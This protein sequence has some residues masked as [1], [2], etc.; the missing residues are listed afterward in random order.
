MKIMGKTKKNLEED[1]TREL[2]DIYP[3][4][5]TKTS[6]MF[7][8]NY[9]NAREGSMYQVWD[10]GAMARLGTLY[11]TER[12]QNS[13]TE[14]QFSPIQIDSIDWLNFMFLRTD[15]STTVRKEEL[16]GLQPRLK[17]PPQNKK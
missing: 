9:T 13:Y 15:E 6:I 17:R 3:F 10:L 14:F 7:P 5:A 8:D 2:R 16:K 11:C 4:T 12:K 1:L